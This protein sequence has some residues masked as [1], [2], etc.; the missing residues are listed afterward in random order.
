M[1]WALVGG[2][3][4]HWWRTGTAMSGTEVGPGGASSTGC[5]EVPNL[6]GRDV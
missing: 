1:A 5:F 4:T 2:R 3:G 6:V